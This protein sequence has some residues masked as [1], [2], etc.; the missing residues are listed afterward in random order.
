MRPEI[1]ESTNDLCIKESEYNR[2][3]MEQNL[4]RELFIDKNLE[5]AN[6]RKEEKY[7]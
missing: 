4:V 6:I 3:T 7:H 5:N 2:K 1:Q